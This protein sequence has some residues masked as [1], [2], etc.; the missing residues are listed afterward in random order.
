MP[1]SIIYLSISAPQSTWQA[2]S[3][4]RC[5]Q[6]HN[7]HGRISHGASSLHVLERL[8]SWFSDHSAYSGPGLSLK[9][10][11]KK[12]TAKLWVLKIKN[13]WV[14]AAVASF[15]IAVV[16]VEVCRTISPSCHLTIG[17]SILF[18]KGTVIETQTSGLSVG[19]ALQ[20][21]NA[22]A[23]RWNR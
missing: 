13:G 19:T 17:H 2:T 20:S 10:K 23:P 5:G 15:I 14:S 21:E 22:N 11:K 7:P 4:G 6:A 12:Q 18:L 9:K 3:G 16:S 1:Q 8:K